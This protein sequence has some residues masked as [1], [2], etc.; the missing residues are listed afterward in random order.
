MTLLPG[1]LFA[2]IVQV[3]PSGPGVEYKQPQIAIQGEFAALTFGSANTVWFSASKDGGR[4]FSAPV[5]V[6]SRGKMALGRHRGPRV[7]IARVASSS[8]LRSVKREAAPME[9]SLPGAPRIRARPG[10]RAFV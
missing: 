7:A 1:L 8:A 2:S 6:S 4:T 10:R 9:I 3:A 5:E